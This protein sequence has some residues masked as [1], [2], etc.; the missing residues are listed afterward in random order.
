[1]LSTRRGEQGRLARANPLLASSL[2]AG[3]LFCNPPTFL[4]RLLLRGFDL[5]LR[6]VKNAQAKSL[7]L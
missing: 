7:A 3:A 1:M 4:L 6:G 2:A 5:A